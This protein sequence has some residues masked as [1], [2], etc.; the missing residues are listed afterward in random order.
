MIDCVNEHLHLALRYLVINSVNAVSSAI[1]SGGEGNKIEVINTN[2]LLLSYVMKILSTLLSN[3][4]S[5]HVDNYRDNEVIEK[6]VEVIV[7]CVNFL[8]E[9]YSGETFDD[10]DSKVDIVENVQKMF[11]AALGTF[12]EICKFNTTIKLS[13]KK[14]LDMLIDESSNKLGMMYL[15]NFMLNNVNSEYTIEAFVEHLTKI[16]KKQ[17]LDLFNEIESNFQTVIKY[18]D[19]IENK[20][21]LQ[22]IIDIATSSN[23]DFL[24]L[25][26]AQVLLCVYKRYNGRNKLNVYEEITEKILSKLNLS[27]N[28]IAKI[29]FFLLE[30]KDI[31]SFLPDFE[32]IVRILKFL[33][34]FIKSDYKFLFIL[35]DVALYY[36]KLFSHFKSY[37]V[38]K[39][40]PIVNELQR[41]LSAVIFDIVFLILEGL[42]VICDSKRNISSKFFYESNTRYDLVEELPNKEQIVAIVKELNSFVTSYSFIPFEASTASENNIIKATMLITKSIDI[43]ASLASNSYGQN[44]L[45]SAEY[46]QSTGTSAVT[47]PKDTTPMISLHDIINKMINAQQIGVKEESILLL[48][49]SIAKLIFVLLYD[50]NFYENIS[51]STTDRKMM[52]ITSTRLK[53][54]VRLIGEEPSTEPKEITISISNVL[55]TIITVLLYF[56]NGE[57]DVLLFEIGKLKGLIDDFP[58]SVDIIDVDV[59]TSKLPNSRKI[60]D[61]FDLINKYYD[62]YKI[63]PY[64]INFPLEIN[65]K[66]TNQLSLSISSSLFN[67]NHSVTINNNIN[68]LPADFK[69]QINEFEKLLNWKKHRIFLSK[70]SSLNIRRNIFD[71]DTCINSLDKKYIF[72]EFDFFKLRKKYFYFNTDQFEQYC[73]FNFNENLLFKTFSNISYA[74]TS[75]VNNKIYV[76]SDEN[77]YNPNI[78]KYFL[79]QL[80]NIKINFTDIP[81]LQESNSVNLM[82]SQNQNLHK[83]KKKIN[84]KINVLIYKPNYEKNAANNKNIIPPLQ[85]NLNKEQIRCLS[86][87]SGRNLST[88]VDNVVPGQ[89]VVNLTYAGIP[90]V[91]QAQPQMQNQT[92]PSSTNNTT[93]SNPQEQQSEQKQQQPTNSASQTNQPTSSI[94]VEKNTPNVDNPQIQPKPVPQT[95]PQQPTQP[96]PNMPLPH[97]MMKIPQPYQFPGMNYPGGFMAAQP[98]MMMNPMMGMNHPGMFPNY[99][100]FQPMMPVP[101]MGVQQMNTVQQPSTNTVSAEKTQQ[102]QVQPQNN[103]PHNNN[104]QKNLVNNLGSILFKLSQ[105]NSGGNNS[106][107]G[108]SNTGNEGSKDPRIR[109]KK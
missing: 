31:E 47:L 50:L 16:Q 38:Q 58:N 55:T 41:N 103:N 101:M 88:H 18:S 67:I 104:Q 27:F 70:E 1:E 69:N 105:N 74:I 14:L 97:P 9:V 35:H 42:S 78:N 109:K 79:Q 19:F 73:H 36:T 5:S 65:N 72:N 23:N 59:T 57:S 64:G 102:P 52:S 94:Q 45:L 28:K 3:L 82:L 108:N 7:D 60:D 61:K 10:E 39:E 8:F 92:N 66:E 34:V 30:E 11:N 4:L 98:G 53:A 63:Q 85:N 89:K 107:N 51:L 26:C 12:R 99:Q 54:L 22:F 95:Q 40:F 68:I 24:V 76:Q 15:F 6:I 29:N 33:M 44:I 48:T 17:G 62:Y 83:I 2:S 87:V 80:S 43:F 71:L 77:D 46:A 106:N 84:S 49:E 25:Q 81:T 86:K 37:I 93:N 75:T 32:S 21:I 96:N 13:F 100:G 91:N 20:N 90:N 56:T